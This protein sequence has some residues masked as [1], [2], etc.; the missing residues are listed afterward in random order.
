MPNLPPLS[1]IRAFEAAARHRNYTRAGE[2][3]GLTQAAVSYQIK[4]LEQRVGAVLFMRSG[5][6]MELTPAGQ[7]LAPRIAQAFATLERAFADFSEGEE[8]VL[9]IACF[10]SYASKFLAPRL[11]KFQ[12]ANP[13]IAVRLDV[14]DHFVDLEAGECDVAIRLSADVPDSLMSYDLEPLELAPC[15]SA[16]FI[17]Q[18]DWPLSGRPQIPGELRISPGFDWWALWDAASGVAMP[19][20]VR[21]QRGLQFDTQVLDAAAAMSGDGVA[22]L[23]TFLFSEEF[24]S[25][26]LQRIGVEPAYPGQMFRLIYPE[27]RRHSAKVRAF[28][29]WLLQEHGHELTDYSTGR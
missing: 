21:S 23:A 22:I 3:L 20:G 27:A 4:S 15:A 10:Q 28:R 16:E 9:T 12:L 6:N 29:A 7:Q 5:R 14:G 18:H 24:A 8:S 17:A 1:A 11:G 2:E 13:D 26:R 19:D 25:G